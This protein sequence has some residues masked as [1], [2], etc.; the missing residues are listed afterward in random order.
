MGLA[1][2]NLLFIYM[3]MEMVG[4][5]AN[6]VADKVTKEV[7]KQVVEEVRS[8]ISFPHGNLKIWHC[9]SQVPWKK[10]VSGCFW[11]EVPRW[12]RMERRC[13]CICPLPSPEM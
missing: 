11:V 3:Y 5:D 2:A 9:S 6:K 10:N 1:S 12:K 13:I 4:R 8:Q 7:N